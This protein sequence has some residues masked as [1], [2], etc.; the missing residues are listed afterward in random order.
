MKQATLPHPDKAAW[1]DLL[2]KMPVEQRDFDLEVS[3]DDIPGCARITIQQAHY[4][5]WQEYAVLQRVAQITAE[6]RLILRPTSCQPGILLCA[7]HAWKHIQLDAEIN[8]LYSMLFGQHQAKIEF[9][10]VPATESRRAQAKLVFLM[11]IITITRHNE[12]RLQFCRC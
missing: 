8:A 5:A 2:T 7:W 12:D 6:Y 1:N 9:L 10:D 11:D 4:R 3:V